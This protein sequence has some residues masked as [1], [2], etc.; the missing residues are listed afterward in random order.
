MTSKSESSGICALFILLFILNGLMYYKTRNELAE[1]KA[2]II[3]LHVTLANSAAVP[4]H[5]EPRG[6]PPYSRARH[7]IEYQ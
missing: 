4:K 7:E 5:P 3:D 6:Y 1:L 2:Q